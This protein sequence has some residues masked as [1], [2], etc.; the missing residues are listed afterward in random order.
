MMG[1]GAGVGGAA[2][3]GGGGDATA[4]AGGVDDEA[5]DWPLSSY[6]LLR[7]DMALEYKILSHCLSFL[8]ILFFSEVVA[9]A[10]IS[11]GD[12]GMSG[13]GAETAGR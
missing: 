12:A 11:N 5:P 9:S 6:F 13:G 8:F 10:G 3:D 1:A 7:F 2:V 4:G